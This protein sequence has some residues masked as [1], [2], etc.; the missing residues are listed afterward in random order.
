MKTVIH[1]MRNHLAVAVANV[2]AFIEG[3][4]VPTQARLNSVMQA[5]NEVDRL[6]GDL[7]VVERGGD[8]ARTMRSELRTIDVCALIANEAMGMESAAHER[9][10]DFTI[11]RCEAVHPACHA[12]RGDPDRIGQVVNNVISNAIRYTPPG[13]AVEVDCQRGPGELVFSVIDDGP[14]IA[15]S[16]QD[17]VFE[18]GFRGRAA[19]GTEGSGFGLALVRSF[20]EQHG[21]TI[22]LVSRVGP[23]HGTTFTIKLPG[24]ADAQ[25]RRGASLQ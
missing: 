2:E 19:A 25:R 10:V 14:G 6:I 17:H 11:R 23:G 4:I 18:R 13:G 22:D 21:G 1:E 7:D 24:Q 20:V 9:G 8:S 5:L 15:Q 16:E 12:F 3:R